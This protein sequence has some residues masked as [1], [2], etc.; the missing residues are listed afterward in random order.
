MQCTP[1]VSLSS[2]GTLYHMR[3][4]NEARQALTTGVFRLNTL[5]GVEANIHKKAGLSTVKFFMSLT[6]NKHN[7][8]FRGATKDG[9][10]TSVV[11]ELD[12]NKLGTK[13]RISPIAYYDL[14]ARPDKN[15]MEERLLSSTETI[16]VKP[17]LQR[18]AVIIGSD[19]EDYST[20]IEELLNWGVPVLAYAS[21]KAYLA[22]RQLPIATAPVKVPVVGYDAYVG[23]RRD[24]AVSPLDAA[25]DF[26]SNKRPSDMLRLAYALVAE[27]QNGNMSMSV[28]MTKAANRLRVKSKLAL[29]MAVVAYWTEREKEYVAAE[30]AKRLDVFRAILSD[31]PNADADKLGRL[32]YLTYDELKEL[33]SDAAVI[34]GF[35]FYK[36]GKERLDWLKDKQHYIKNQEENDKALS[37]KVDVWVS[38]LEEL[39][40]ELG[41]RGSE[42]LRTLL[43]SG[44]LHLPDY[45]SSYAD[46]LFP[47]VRDIFDDSVADAFQIRRM[48]RSYLNKL[49]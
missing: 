28:E 24:H 6:R 21:L 8:F 35:P 40:R 11:Y 16:Q 23:N 19:G 41:D 29:A 14:H 27:A 33:G 25:L 37:A 26:E 45:T 9:K 36:K 31:F 12:G 39:K 48:L 5:H 32:Q 30:N 46:V 7:D 22:N 49:D 3:S 34:D 15:E 10:V 43:L 17:Y 47:K 44:H 2:R 13:Y 4:A 20:L 42:Y 38:L 18:I 1:A